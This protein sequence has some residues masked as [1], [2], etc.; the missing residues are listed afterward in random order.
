MWYI[1][2]ILSNTK[3]GRGALNHIFSLQILVLAH[4]HCSLWRTWCMIIYSFVEP[5]IESHNGFSERTRNGMNRHEVKNGIAQGLK[6]LK[7]ILRPYFRIFH[8]MASDKWILNWKNLQ[9]SEAKIASSA[10]IAL[11]VFYTQKGWK[12][13]SSYPII[14][15]RRNQ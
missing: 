15:R 6:D 11:C 1:H 9:P 3:A 7:V 10:S 2:V 4:A 13:V 12:L 5:L 14:T 8:K